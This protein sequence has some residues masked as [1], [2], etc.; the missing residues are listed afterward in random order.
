MKSPISM[1]EALALCDINRAR[2]TEPDRSQVLRAM[3]VWP[4]RRMIEQTVA[5]RS[6]RESRR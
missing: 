4:W 3:S 5:T 2:R 6:W 1:R